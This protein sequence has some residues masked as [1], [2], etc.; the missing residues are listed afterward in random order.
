MKKERFRIYQ[1]MYDSLFKDMSKALTLLG[2]KDNTSVDNAIQVLQNAQCKTEDIYVNQ[3]HSYPY[4][5]LYEDIYNRTN[6]QAI[7]YFIKEGS[8]LGEKNNTSFT[9]R[10]DIA[11][12][13]L[14]K[15]LQQLLDEQTLKKIYPSI[16]KYTASKEEIQF[17]LGMKIGAK[18]ALSLTND[19]EYDF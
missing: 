15:E 6:L 19:S 4:N 18:I 13:E 14:E 8:T 10:E 17:S 12:K 2:Q 7:G 11:E 5:T 1:N 3:E 16:I 9:E